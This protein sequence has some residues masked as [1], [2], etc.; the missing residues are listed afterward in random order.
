[1][2]RYTIRSVEKTPTDI[3]VRHDGGGGLVFLRADD[4][5]AIYENDLR[6][7]ITEDVLLTMLLVRHRGA[8][9][10]LIGKTVTF[11]PHDPGGAIVRVL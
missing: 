2:T 7:L 4:E 1:M 3:H 11:D 6:K 10:K 9:E 5:M 8:E